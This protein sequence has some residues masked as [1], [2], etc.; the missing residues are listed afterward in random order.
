M[1]LVMGKKTPF[2]KY[3]PYGNNFVIIDK[4]QT[5]VFSE[6]GKVRFADFATNVYF[7]ASYI[8]PMPISR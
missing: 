1:K 8:I 7:G 6:N 3:I 2:V 4:T 5:P